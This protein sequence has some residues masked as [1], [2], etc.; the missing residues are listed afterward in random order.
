M[1]R[2]QN[3][4]LQECLQT[5]EQINH[6][7]DYSPNEHGSYTE[8]FQRVIRTLDNLHFFDQP[9]QLTT[10]ERV[11]EVL[12]RLAFIDSDNG[13]LCA[14]WA[15]WCL[16]KWLILL[17]LHPNSVLILKCECLASPSRDNDLFRR[18]QLKRF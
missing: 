9:D 11:L 1:S 13:P 10:Q 17:Q 14:A 7:L 2:M 15:D 4:E 3:G 12:Q 8:S 5:I 6:M 16:Q 18:P